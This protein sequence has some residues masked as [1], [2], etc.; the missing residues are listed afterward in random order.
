MEQLENKYCTDI[1]LFLIF[2]LDYIM[3]MFL[4]LKEEILKIY[5]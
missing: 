2:S 4:I 5:K 1:D 3:Y